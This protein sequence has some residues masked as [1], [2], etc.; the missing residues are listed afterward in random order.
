MG[1]PICLISILQHWVCWEE[2]GPGCCSS[3]AARAT[4]CNEKFFYNPDMQPVQSKALPS[5]IQTAK[6][7]KGIGSSSVIPLPSDVIVLSVWNPSL[8]PCLLIT[9]ITLITSLSKSWITSKK[10]LGFFMTVHVKNHNRLSAFPLHC[11][12]FSFQCF[13]SW[14]ICPATFLSA[15]VQCILAV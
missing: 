5:A 11:S 3:A 13:I 9:Y 10:P 2:G 6:V 15:T 1:W 4:C 14:I 7:F 12:V 8:C